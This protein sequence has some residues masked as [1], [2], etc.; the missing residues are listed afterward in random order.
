M[1][2]ELIPHWVLF[3]I[4]EFPDGSSEWRCF[5]MKALHKDNKVCYY[6]DSVEL[7]IDYFSNT[8]Y[9][10]INIRLIAF[11]IHLQKK[12]KQRFKII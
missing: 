2:I 12:K 1:K 11:S 9:T 8:L 6:L 3:D 4:I 5:F 10:S 7:G